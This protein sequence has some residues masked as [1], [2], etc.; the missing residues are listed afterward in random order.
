MSIRNEPAITPPTIGKMGPYTVFV[1]PSDASHFSVSESRSKHYI[2]PTSIQLPPVKSA[3]L[4]QPPPVQYGKSIPSKFGLFWDAVAK[5]QNAHSNLDEFVAHWF[6]LNQSKYQWAL[7]D[8]YESRGVDNK[9]D[10]R[11]KDASTKAQ[12]V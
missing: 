1:T 11:A 2:P 4:V 6:G 5:V 8:Y 3:P 9:V 12:R 7:D 10:T